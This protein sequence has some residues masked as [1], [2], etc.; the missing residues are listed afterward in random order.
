MKITIK[1][2][3]V[4]LFATILLAPCSNPSLNTPNISDKNLSDKSTVKKFTIKLAQMS[5]GFNEDAYLAAFPDIANAVKSGAL[6]SGFA[7]YLSFG[8]TEGQL[9]WTIYITARNAVTLWQLLK[10]L[11]S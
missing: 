10:I 11:I 8:K 1:L 9:S 3:Y 5:D 7:H 6:S 2:I 4:C